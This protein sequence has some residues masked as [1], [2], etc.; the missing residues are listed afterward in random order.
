MTTS[1]P[2]G[3]APRAP[4]PPRPCAVVDL[5][6][7]EVLDALRDVGQH[8]DGGGRDFGG[9]PCR[10]VAPQQPHPTAEHCDQQDAD[11]QTQA[12]SHDRA[13][14]APAPWGVKAARSR[15]A[16][17]G[18]A[19]RRP[20]R[21]APRERRQSRMADMTID[22]AGARRRAWGVHLYTGSGAVLALLALDAIGRDALR[23]RRSPGWRS[24]CSSTAPTARWRAARA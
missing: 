3:T 8:I 1:R 11:Q 18:A 5:D 20:A 10:G 23:R 15:R 14:L 24:R 19:P 9:A 4:T 7:M 16:R 22:D 2:R 12:R 13:G 17:R 21:R 6:A